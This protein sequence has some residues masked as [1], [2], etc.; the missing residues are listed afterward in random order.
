MRIGVIGAT[1][2]LGLRVVAEAVGRGHQVRAFTR[3]LTTDSHRPDVEWAAID[4]LDPDSVTA[5]IGGLDVLVSSYQPGNGVKDFDDVLRR[6]VK[7]PSGYVTA[8]K[9]L[10]KGLNTYPSTRLIVIGGAGSLEIE[11]GVV[12][13]DL[14]DLMRADLE[15]IGLP[16]D[17]VVAVQGHRDA[18]NTYRLSNRLWTYISPAEYVFPG[19]RTGRFRLGGDQPVVDANGQS[20]ISYEDLA[21]A[22]L[23]EAELPSHIQRR[24][25]L[26][27]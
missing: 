21:V 4:V 22:I 13:A 16:A 26:G 27:Y 19:E 5:A 1:G 12:K 15:K 6:S 14:P 20:S 17:Y 24:F 3:D 8:A 18:L 23:D 7:D 25:T 11:P 2:N 10:L 9:A